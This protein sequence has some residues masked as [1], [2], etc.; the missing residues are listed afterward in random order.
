MANRIIPLI[1]AARTSPDRTGDSLYQNLKTQFSGNIMSAFDKKVETFE[2]IKGLQD[3]H[4]YL[5]TLAPVGN[6]VENP[7]LNR[8]AAEIAAE[9][10]KTGDTTH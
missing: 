3:L 7:A 2:G 9:K 5:S 6:L 4:K 1:N 8:A 10:G